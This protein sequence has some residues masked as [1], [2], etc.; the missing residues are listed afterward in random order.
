MKKPVNLLFMKNT[1]KIISSVF[2]LL[3]ISILIYIYYRSIFFHEGAKSYYYY[4]YYIFSFILIFLSIIS[5]FVSKKIKEY[6]SI[7]LV[8]IIF[9]LYCFEVHM[10]Y[11]LSY[12]GVLNKKKEISKNLGIKYDLRTKLEIYQDLKKKDPNIVTN[13]RFSSTEI[14]NMN[15]YPFSGVSNSKTIYCN[16][17]GYYSIYQSDRYGFNNP[18]EEWDKNITDFLL[19][20]DSQ[21]H[22][23]CVNRP[24]DFASNLRLL[25]K[26]ENGVLNL[27]YYGIGPLIEY[28]VLREYL[29]NK[30]VKNILWMYFEGNDLL[31]LK[32][33]LTKP[34]LLKYLENKSFHQ[35]LISKQNIIDEQNKKDIEQLV[36]E[37]KNISHKLLSKNNIINFVK[38]YHVRLLIF[39]DKPQPEISSG[40]KTTFTE[41]LKSANELAKE[42]NSKLY[43]VYLPAYE[44]YKNTYYKSPYKKVINLV[45]NLKIPLINIHLN[46]FKNHNDPSS[47]FSIWGRE[48]YPRVGSNDHYSVKGYKLISKEIYKFIK[49]NK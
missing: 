30:N 49:T 19:V 6:A 35:N 31:D 28:A 27:G 21:T 32:I 38:L 36:E 3:S 8:S 46:V 48:V 44:R 17:N 9:A 1:S 2:L 18:D 20:G 11:K 24:Y 13:F 25:K 10:I 23:A 39:T 22:G 42:N 45:N 7:V 41:I 15:L 40:R 47:L 16:E 5:F 26:N 43:F 14:K 4:R 12:E 34:I 29:K 33:E 37:Q